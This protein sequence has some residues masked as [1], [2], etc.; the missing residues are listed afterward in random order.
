MI[1]ELVVLYFLLIGLAA[2]GSLESFRLKQRDG[3]PFVRIF[4]VFV[5]LAFAYALVN[6]VG[7]VVVP[8]IFPGPSET[9]I[10]TYMIVDLITIPLLGVLFYLLFSW[11]VRLLDWKIGPGLKAAFW[12][13]EALYLIAFFV[14]LI[15]YFVRGISALTYAA[16]VIL[17]GVL[18]LM[19]LAAVLTLAL[20]DPE[21]EDPARR[22]LVRGLGIRYAY[23][24]VAV[25]AI[26][27]VARTT[28]FGTT[29]AGRILPA[30]FVFLV[31][32]PALFFLRRVSLSWASFPGPEAGQT[33]GLAGIS[34]EEGLT[35]REKEIIRL[36]ARGLDTR[37]IGK[38]LFI[39]PKTVK[40]HLTNIYVKTGVRNRVQLVNRY[41]R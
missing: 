21:G 2:W 16:V 1:L 4:H 19:L 33:G 15:S 23:S 37:E 27:A 26:L 5:L 29:M 20:A 24:L 36:I 9:L 39:S 12:G 38:A 17:N 40:N 14:S 3:R 31:N 18:L 13:A 41:R 32:F 11:I 8:A 6:F 34:D 10:A 35:D 7:E 28:P 25:I 30:A 22:R